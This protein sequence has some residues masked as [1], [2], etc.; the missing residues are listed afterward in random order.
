MNKIIRKS[1]K[2]SLIVAAVLMVIYIFLQII[3][4]NYNYGVGPIF[5]ILDNTTQTGCHPVDSSNVAVPDD[6]SLLGSGV[7]M[8]CVD[9]PTSDI[10]LVGIASSYLVFF[11]IVFATYYLVLMARGGRNNRVSKSK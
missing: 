6:G 9:G 3:Y 8:L 10:T 4:Y 7:S 1:I 2:R 11:V 5:S